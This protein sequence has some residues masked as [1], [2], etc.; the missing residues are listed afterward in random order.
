MYTAALNISSDG[1]EHC[2]A[3][4]NGKA[5]AY[6]LR[7]RFASHSPPAIRLP[8]RS[9]STL[10]QRLCSLLL[11]A[12]TTGGTM[13]WRR[14]SWRPR[15]TTRTTPPTSTTK[16]SPTSSSTNSSRRRPCSKRVR[17]FDRNLGKYGTDILRDFGIFDGSFR[18]P[19]LY[20]GGGDGFST[21]AGQDYYEVTL[22]GEDSGLTQGA[23]CA[24]N[25]G[26][27]IIEAH[28]G[29]IDGPLITEVRFNSI[30]MPF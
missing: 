16:A 1:A 11:C 15:S 8:F 4:H 21:D 17:Y 2:A 9:L 30:L 12:V 19:H 27:G 6:G 22:M 25:T 13:L 29:A 28:Y 3:C 14:G 5:T 7:G 20:G 10:L 24:D 26:C 23:T 18:Q